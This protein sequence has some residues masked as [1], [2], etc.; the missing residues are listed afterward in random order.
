MTK[1]EKIE[2]LENKLGEE[3]FTELLKAVLNSKYYDDY[4][5]TFDHVITYLYNMAELL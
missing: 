5:L 2:F 1:Y 3:K 4:Q